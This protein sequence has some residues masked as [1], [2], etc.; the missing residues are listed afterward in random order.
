MLG[1]CVF[2]TFLL[3]LFFGVCPG[4]QKARTDDGKQV[5]LH[6]DGTWEYSEV[7]TMKEKD[8]LAPK[9]LKKTTPSYS[10]EAK[11]AKVEGLVLVK[12][13]IRK[14]GRAE[15]CETLQN[16]SHGL[17]ERFIQEVQRN[18]KF[19]PGHLHGRPV[20][21]EVAIETEFRLN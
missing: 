4:Q 2:R 14:S 5:V 16:L 1:R 21:V 6:G 17:A 12:C 7:F 19:E 8:L 3:F 13:I 9:I 15:S 11:A 20:D 10:E 18:W